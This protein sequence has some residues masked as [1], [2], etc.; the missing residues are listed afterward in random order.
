MKYEF[1]STISEHDYEFENIVCKM[2]AICR[3]LNVLSK[4]SNHIIN[5][6][7]TVLQFVSTWAPFPWINCVDAVD[8]LLVI[9]LIWLKSSWKLHHEYAKIHI[10]WFTPKMVYCD[11]D[12]VEV[13]H[14][15][16]DYFVGDNEA[17]VTNNSK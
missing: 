10:R 7:N 12:L 5:H 16:Q 9:H 15:L 4:A 13:T 2:T 17:V 11:F 8:S 1:T 3:S 14:I 6:S